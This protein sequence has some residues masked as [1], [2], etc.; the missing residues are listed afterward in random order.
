MLINAC[1]A[2]IGIWHSNKSN[3]LLAPFNMITSGAHLNWH[4]IPMEER[5]F[6]DLHLS[7]FQCLL[8]HCILRHCIL[9]KLNSSLWTYCNWS[10]KEL[11]YEFALCLRLANLSIRWLI[12]MEFTT[13]LHDAD[14][15]CFFEIRIGNS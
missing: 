8:R 6:V 9:R 1:D 3:V 4:K 12:V 15:G 13:P 10:E 5:P 7:S 2:L 11:N 14:M